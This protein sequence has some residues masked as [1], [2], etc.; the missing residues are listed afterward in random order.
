MY[1]LYFNLGIRFTSW[2]GVC[3]FVYDCGSVLLHVLFLGIC[4]AFIESLWLLNINHSWRCVLTSQRSVMG[5][6]L[7][8]LPEMSPDTL[9]FSDGAQSLYGSSSQNSAVFHTRTVTSL[10]R[11]ASIQVFVLLLTHLIS[12]LNSVHSSCLKMTINTEQNVELKS[13]DSLLLCNLQASEKTY[14]YSIA[15]LN[16]WHGSNG[17]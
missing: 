4:L 14:I 7:L 9:S 15:P 5:Q 8:L 3:V 12:A 16:Q 6:N 2:S 10:H 13:I 17:W 11:L 1:L